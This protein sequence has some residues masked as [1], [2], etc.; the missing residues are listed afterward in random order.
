MINSRFVRF[1]LLIVIPIF[2][3]SSCKRDKNDEII[4]REQ[5]VKI[6]TEMQIDES[7]MANK[8]W[9][10]GV[11]TDSTKSYYNY[12]FK[13][14]NITRKTFDNSLAYYSKDLE[15]L[16]KMYDEVIV[17]I[18]NLI[19][20]TL[21]SKSLYNIVVN[22]IAEAEMRVNPVKR[23]GEAGTELWTNKNVYNLPGDSVKTD[24]IF[25]K[26]IKHKC[27]LVLKA[28]Y[29]VLP[30]NKSKNMKMNMIVFYNDS[31]SDT[32]QKK[33]KP[34]I[35]KLLVFHLTYKTDSIKLPINVK[36]T[37]F[38][39][40]SINTNTRISITNISLKQYAPKTD[41]TALFVL[42]AKL[43]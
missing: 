25:E 36:S 34:K 29:T 35:G 2:F 21:N 33:I 1:I 38:T 27:L 40:D 41:T 14:H 15:D 20:K 7:I 23:F 32:I 30:D 12:I 18:G 43:K 31:T 13:K 22:T 8:G 39:A 28:E 5:F 16:I 37:I 24:I 42:P 11:L 19:P 9:F 17:E 26:E 6:L 10:D 3:F 4:E